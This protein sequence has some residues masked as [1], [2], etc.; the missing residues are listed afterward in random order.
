MREMSEIKFRYRIKDTLTGKIEVRYLTLNQIEGGLVFN[1][2]GLKHDI[3]SRDQ[4]TGRKDKNEKEIYE[5]DVLTA[6]YDDCSKRHK[7]YFEDGCFKLQWKEL[8]E[9]NK[10]DIEIIGNIYEDLRRD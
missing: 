8:D 5:G 3:L 2:V 4:F 7:V 6:P 1:G 10:K 9:W